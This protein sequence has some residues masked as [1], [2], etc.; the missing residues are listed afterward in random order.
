MNISTKYYEGLFGEFELYHPYLAEHVVDVEPWG[1][2]GIRVTLEDGSRFN[3]ETSSHSIRRV[4]EHKVE[5]IDDITDDS[6]RSAFAVNL[7]D[8]MTARGFTQ[9][10]L[11]EYSGLSKGVINKYV[12]KK[13]TPT[14]TAV[15]RLAYALNCAPAELM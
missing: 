13:A 12:N 10:T 5:Q 2:R 9:Q 15:Y 3:Y 7:I 11:A 8:M 4:V 14:V 1:E 6:C